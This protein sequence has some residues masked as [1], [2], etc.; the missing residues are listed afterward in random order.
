MAHSIS[1][2]LRTAIV[3]AAFAWPQTSM[4]EVA[5]RVDGTA[6]YVTLTLVNQS[7][8]REQKRAE[9]PF[10][11]RFYAKPGQFIYLSAQKSTMTRTEHHMGYD[12]TEVVYDGVAGT[13]HVSIRVTG[14][15]I[16]E[17]SSSSPYGVATAEGKVSE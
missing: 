1:D 4:K 3:F 10:E 13:V 17:A 7:G 15:M 9:L 14:A 5:Y 11:L 16:Q 12:A 6:K 8:G 2:T